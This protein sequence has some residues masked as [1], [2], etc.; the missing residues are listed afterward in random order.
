MRQGGKAM[1]EI[2]IGTSIL[3]AAPAVTAFGSQYAAV[4]IGADHSIKAQLFAANGAKSGSEFIVSPANP[5]LKRGQ[6]AV[7]QCRLGLVVC[8]VDRPGA[9]ETRVMIRTFDRN[10][11]KPG[12]EIQVNSTNAETSPRPALASTADGGFVVVWVDK[13]QDRRIRLQRFGSDGQRMNPDFR[14][15]T[16]PGRHSQPMVVRRTDGNVLVAWRGGGGMVRFQVLGEEGPVGGERNTGVT[17]TD[18]AMTSADDGQ[19]VIATVLGPGDIDGPPP[20]NAVSLNGFDAGGELSGTL[21]PANDPRVRSFEPQL[22]PLSGGPILLA[23]TEHPLG[24]PGIDGVA[25]K[26]RVISRS[27]GASAQ[28]NSFMGGQRSGVRVAAIPDSAGDTAFLVWASNASKAGGASGPSVVGR[29]IAISPG[30]FRDA[31]AATS[32]SELLI[33]SGTQ[34]IQQQPALASMRGPSDP[35]FVAVWADFSDAS[36][37]GQRLAVSGTRIGG[38]FIVNTPT[39]P[40][41]NARRRQPAVT[42]FGDSFAVAWI[43]N[44]SA[45]PGPRPHVKLQMFGRDATKSGPEIQVSSTDV[46]AAQAPAMARLSDGGFVVIWADARRDR[47]I[48]AQRFRSDG[49]KNGDEFGVNAAEGLH[50]APIVTSL[51]GGTF[52]VAWMRDPASPGGGGLI[53]RIFDIEGHATGDEIP[54][55]LSGFRGAKAITALDDGRFA[56]AHVR[57]IGKND[58]GEE[59]SVVEGRILEADGRD[60]RIVFA[61]THDATGDPNAEGEITSSSPALAPLPGGRFVLVWGQKKASTA[62]T[63]RFVRAKVFSASAG[64]VGGIVQVN[65]AESGDRFGIC[66]ATGIGGGGTPTIFVAWADDSKKGGD[67]SDFAVR[68]RPLPIVASGGVA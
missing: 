51:A 7:I 13:R 14:V 33:N 30:G 23:W 28:I 37:R 1:D 3:G 22:A 4:W 56:I 20:P 49:S 35:Q 45:P 62:I 59:L 9:Q 52:V 43:E 38:E 65:N 66:A 19:F 25:V 12:P 44:A 10:A 57:R 67:A 46:D 16:E 5:A 11:L 64:S 47:R 61:A 18:A 36:V 54:V 40:S 63:N 32:T 68:G 39:P 2:L 27:G 53:V 15:N 41:G 8:W 21:D 17:A 48:R 6:V 55:N 42:A 24:G 58:I 34:G 29:A 50:E 31:V 26:A 60:P